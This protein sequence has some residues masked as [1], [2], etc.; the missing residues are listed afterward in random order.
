MGAAPEVAVIE[1]ISD[2]KLDVLVVDD[3]EVR[4]STT[5]AH[6]D[7]AWSGRARTVHVKTGAEALALLERRSFDVCLLARQLGSSSGLEFL[8]QARAAGHDLP[9]IVVT[10]DLTPQAAAEASEAGA[11]DR[12]DVGRIGPDG[13]SHA[14]RFARTHR[15]IV[16]ELRARNAELARAAQDKNV[17][18][19][20]AAHDLRSPI[21]VIRGYTELLLEHPEELDAGEVAEVLCKIRTSCATMTELIDDLLDVSS[22][23]AGTL[24]LR[25]MPCDL[26][27]L[28]REVMSA[29]EHMASAKDIRLSL[30]LAADPVPPVP[31]D[32][33]RF[34]Q[35]LAN[36]VT[37]AIK[38]SNRGTEVT[39]RVDAP[40][41]GEA[42]VQ[43]TD[44]GIGIAPDFVPKLFHPFARARRTGTS[45][46]KS[47]GLGLAI[48]HR[49]V[50]AHGGRLEVQSQLGEGSTFSVTLPR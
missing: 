43:V 45:G 34:E 38:Y 46:E 9:V 26:V 41:A 44:H 8:R 24:V 13:L 47:T 25:K 33:A 1:P 14:I 6:L 29:H 37:N 10:A 23:E 30:V 32:R 15:R 42:R 5:R 48:A 2:E 12:V 28:A 20:M 17:L 35:V 18:L 22:I 4:H 21:G 3:D 7:L 27:A 19:G 36:L 40:S 16:R 49:V 11:D 50:E 31:A 39:L